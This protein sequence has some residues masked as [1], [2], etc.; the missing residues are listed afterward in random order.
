MPAIT[1]Y[2]FLGIFF[3]TIINPLT[4]LFDE[5]YSELEYRYIDRVDKF[6]SITKNGLWLKQDNQ[7]KNLSSV[8][9]AREIKE[10]GKAYN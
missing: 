10:Q 5:R 3:I 1:L 4:A 2:I 8:L 9:Y 6:A 7:E